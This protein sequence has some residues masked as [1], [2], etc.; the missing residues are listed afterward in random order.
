MDLADGFDLFSSGLTDN[1]LEVSMSEPLLSYKLNYI[2]F[3]L[4][5]TFRAFPF[6]VC[7]I[8]ST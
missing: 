2:N 6:T 7:Q 3:E 1:E 8:S 5:C 4:S